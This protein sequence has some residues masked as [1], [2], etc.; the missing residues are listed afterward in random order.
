MTNQTEDRKS[1]LKDK[2]EALDQINKGYDK[3]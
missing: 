2:V 3:I 1:G